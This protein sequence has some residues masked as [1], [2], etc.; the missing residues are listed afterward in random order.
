MYRSVTINVKKII[1]KLIEQPN[2]GRDKLY[3]GEGPRHVKF[4][5][6]SLTAQVRDEYD[7]A[8]RAI[9][10]TKATSGLN[11][12]P[13]VQKFFESDESSDLQVEPRIL[14]ISQVCKELGEV[15]SG[16]IQI[17]GGY[18]H[19]VSVTPMEWYDPRSYRIC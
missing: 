17:E 14:T 2:S 3:L 5:V 10:A 9:R 16:D 4:D 19:F 1:E 6:C 18:F 8:D 13:V 12:Y 15:N 11:I 7:L